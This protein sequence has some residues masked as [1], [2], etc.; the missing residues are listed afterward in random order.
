M[1]AHEAQRDF[2]FTTSSH[3]IGRAGLLSDLRR[4]VS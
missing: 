3:F 4:R 2:M 1:G